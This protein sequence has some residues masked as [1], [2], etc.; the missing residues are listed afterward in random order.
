MTGRP[1][2]IFDFNS[3]SDLSEWAIVDDVVMGGRSDSYLDINKEGQGDFHGVVS[4][5]N[6]GGFASTRYRPSPIP[7]SGQLYC[8]LKVKGDGKDYQFRI[9]EYE[10]ERFSYIYNFETSGDWETIEIPLLEMY[11]SF[12]GRRLDKPDYAA[13]QISEVA[14]LISNKRNENFQLLIDSIRLE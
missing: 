10:D 3:E 4:L 6:N 5:E 11:P 8:K 14:I 9:K 1:L 13:R 2:V 12:R 7:L